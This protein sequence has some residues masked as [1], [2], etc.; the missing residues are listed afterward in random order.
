MCIRC[1]LF[2]GTNLT[3]KSL[4]L[5]FSSSDGNGAVLGVLIQMYVVFG[6][7]TGDVFCTVVYCTVSH[8]SVYKCTLLRHRKVIHFAA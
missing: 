6:A 3:A 7:S 1:E 2:L 8:L 5:L 4:I